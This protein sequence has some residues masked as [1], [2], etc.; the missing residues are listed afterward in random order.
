LARD[1]A[2]GRQDRGPRTGPRVAAP[3]GPTQPVGSLAR[4]GGR[5]LGIDAVEEVLRLVLGPT[6]RCAVGGPDPMGATPG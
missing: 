5:T 1:G 2:S 4:V 6:G 3:I